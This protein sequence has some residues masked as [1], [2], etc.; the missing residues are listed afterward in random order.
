MTP[1]FHSKKLINDDCHSLVSMCDYIST[2]YR[3]RVK[4]KNT[5]PLDEEPELEKVE[6]QPI[7]ARA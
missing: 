3:S 5:V 2:D 6:E 1:E 7:T 4:A